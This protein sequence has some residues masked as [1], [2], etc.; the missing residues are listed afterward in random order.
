MAGES[1]FKTQE[2]L[3]P[4]FVPQKLPGREAQTKEIAEAFK[5]A[6]KGGSPLPLWVFGRTGVG[7]TSCVKYVARELE[8]SARV[9][10]VY[11]NCWQ[12]YTRQGILSELARSLGEALP[13]RGLAGDEVFSRAMQ[14]CKNSQTVP[15]VVL[16]EVDQLAANNEEKVLYDLV[17]A[18]E[19]FGV[20]LGLACIT[21][22]EAAL[23]RLDDRV[24]SAFSSGQIRFD[25]YSP[26][27]LK[28]ILGSRLNAFSRGSVTPEAIAL[29]AAIGAKNGGDARIAIQLLL[30]AGRNADKRGS[31]FVEESD[32]P[33][34]SAASTR[35]KL[36]RLSENEEK[37]YSLVEDGMH[38]GELYAAAKKAGVE[39][40]ERSIRNILV[41]LEKKRFLELKDSSG[42]AGRTRVLRRL[43]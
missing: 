4:D 9:R 8:E 20:S 40:S 34:Q 27:Q 7:K 19:V 12:N 36:S 22:D 25:P 43:E 29:C 16:D 18:K 13:R 26:K 42:A 33:E 5:P 38:S 11:V 17:R 24:R 31:E 37:I 28:E 6:L 21:N 14:A 32:V 2:F 1:V 39:L 15:I 3:E 41:S 30:A 35:K 23:A 10:V